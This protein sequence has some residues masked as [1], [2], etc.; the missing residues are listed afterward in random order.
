MKSPEGR[1]YGNEDW[2]VDNVDNG[3]MSD[4]KTQPETLNRC[5]KFEAKPSIGREP[6]DLTGTV[7]Q[8]SM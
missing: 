6:S 3:M 8:D 2:K 5:H 7:H 4:V 1:V